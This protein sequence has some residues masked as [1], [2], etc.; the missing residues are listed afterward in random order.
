MGCRGWWGSR[1]WWI[2]R[3]G[4]YRGGG[5][6]EGRIGSGPETEQVQST[7]GVSTEWTRD[8]AGTDHR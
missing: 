6:L 1:G 4:V 2:P 8:R 7:Y 5:D 3:V